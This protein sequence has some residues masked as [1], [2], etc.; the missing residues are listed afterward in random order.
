MG[1]GSGAE[2]D[3]KDYLLFH[4][5]LMQNSFLVLIPTAAPSQPHLTLPPP[6]PPALPPV[7]MASTVQT[8][9]LCQSAPPFL[10]QSSTSKHAHTSGPAVL[11]HWHN[12]N[13]S[14]SATA[15]L[16][17][18]LCPRLSTALL[19]R[20]LL[21]GPGCTPPLTSLC[22]SDGAQMHGSHQENH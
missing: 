5:P 1:K 15:L 3:L 21:P 12:H 4:A 2:P 14:L 19:A 17:D 16:H 6:P 7:L 20:V 10:T 13:P 8:A 22:T 9:S 18:H 11:S